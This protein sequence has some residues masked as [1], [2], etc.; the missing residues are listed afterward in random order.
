MFKNKAEKERYIN[1]IK[2]MLFGNKISCNAG[3]MK[4]K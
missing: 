1:I 2:Y 4:S 3:K